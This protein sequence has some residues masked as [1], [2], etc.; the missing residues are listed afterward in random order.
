MSRVRL[1]DEDIARAAALVCEAMILPD[2]KDCRY[3]FSEA[4]ERKME[5]LIR[6]EKRHSNSRMFLK[7]ALAMVVA[8][9]LGMA[10][11]L[12]IDTDARAA[13]AKWIREVYETRIIYRSMGKPED[14]QLP[15][16]NIQAVPEGYEIVKEG[17]KDK[18]RYFI[19]EKT[20]ETKDRIV[21]LYRWNNDSRMNIVLE[22]EEYMHEHLKVGTYSAE[23]HQAINNQESNLLM[24]VDEGKGIIFSIDSTLTKAEILG[25]AESVKLTK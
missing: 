21:F 20:S 8:A 22:P 18:F 11:W 15:K 14:S 7:R 17:E 25:M 1:R 19:W 13:F 9:L 2:P 3:T 5:R 24:W 6:A 23:W 12:S 4:F 16:Y 10:T